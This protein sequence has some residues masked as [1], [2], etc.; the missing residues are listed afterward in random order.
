MWPQFAQLHGSNEV[1]KIVTGPKFNRPASGSRQVDVKKPSRELAGSRD[2]SYRDG[3]IM[4]LRA[5]RA[6]LSSRNVH[7][8]YDSNELPKIVIEA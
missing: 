5:H 2:E 6:K 1:R 8:I 7:N 3:Y 4:R